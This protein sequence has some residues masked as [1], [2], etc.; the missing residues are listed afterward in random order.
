M[1]ITYVGQSNNIIPDAFR[2]AWA[3][4]TTA[5]EAPTFRT[6]TI[7]KAPHECRYLSGEYDSYACALHNLNSIPFN[8]EEH[9][10]SEFFIPKKTGGLRKILAPTEPLKNIQRMIVT[11]L[12][13]PGR[14]LTHN[15]AYAYVK[16]VSCQDAV[17][18]HQKNESKW[19]LKI[20]LKDFFPSCEEHVVADSLSQLYP[21][22]GVEFATLMD[23]LH[24]WCFYQ[25]ALPQGAV[26]SPLLSNLVMLPYDYEI[27]TALRDY[28]GHNFIYTRY[29]D[30]ILISCKQSFNKD[31]VVKMLTEK[32][33]PFIIKHE[34]TRYGSSAGRNWNLGRML[35]KDNDITIGHKQK[36]R[37]RAM[38]QTLFADY[39][40]QDAARVWTPHDVSVLQGLYS[41]Y[42][43]I[44]PEY[45][46]FALE[47]LE[48]KYGVRLQNIRKDTTWISTR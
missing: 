44:E 33:I 4:Q 17:K 48:N 21:I 36:Q 45:I 37:F 7:K 39:T 35:N 24:K 32:L 47:R 14:M 29:A 34:K 12:Q 42:Y 16:G 43:S 1:Y 3:G 22:A 10:Y 30:D 5:P 20:D 46:S 38:L 19:F 13:G 28:D 23:V 41:Y 18:R 27:S 6:K 40:S 26:T 2:A 8:P 31:N 25:G 9:Y 15:A 11:A